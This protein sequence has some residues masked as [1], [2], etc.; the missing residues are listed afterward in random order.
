[1]TSIIWKQE[2]IENSTLHIFTSLGEI[3]TSLFNIRIMPDNA[4]ISGSRGS[5][6]TVVYKE[7]FLR[8]K[9]SEL[10]CFLNAYMLEVFPLAD[11][12]SLNLTTSTELFEKKKTPFGTVPILSHLYLIRPLASGNR[13]SLRIPFST[14]LFLS[15]ESGSVS[16]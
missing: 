2:F 15:V 11:T 10:A 7:A 1:M 13:N 6:M 16:T 14:D 8:G 4:S 9:Q 12:S 3:W 5:L